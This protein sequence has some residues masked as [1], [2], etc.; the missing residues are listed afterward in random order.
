MRNENR[1]K[2]FAKYLS[3]KVKEFLIQDSDL[4]LSLSPY[5]L[6]LLLE[7]LCLSSSEMNSFF[8]IMFT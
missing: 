6:L 4:R 3:R 8:A 7:F 5:F 2:N 1:W